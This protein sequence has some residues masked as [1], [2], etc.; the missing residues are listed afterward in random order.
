V[1]VTTLVLA[2]VT[3][4]CCVTTGLVSSEQPVNSSAPAMIA[5]MVFT[6]GTSG[7]RSLV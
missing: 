3:M 1:I 7:L 6:T 4:G 2:G 5:M